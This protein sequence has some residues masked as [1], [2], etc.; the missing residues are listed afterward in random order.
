MATTVLYWF[1]PPLLQ[2]PVTVEHQSA[3]TRSERLV[4]KRA[5][6]IKVNKRLLTVALRYVHK[7]GTANIVFIHSA[8]HSVQNPC[9]V[10]KRM[11]WI[12]I[13]HIN[14][15]NY[16]NRFNKSNPKMLVCSDITFEEILSHEDRRAF[17]ECMH[18]FGTFCFNIQISFIDGFW[19]LW[20]VYKFYCTL[21]QV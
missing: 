17:S 18:F 14:S 16:G 3:S 9:L 5:K 20:W 11:T 2:K 1:I 19:E 15:N 13:E 4:L 7:K 21:S 8:F 10:A 6:T 12:Y